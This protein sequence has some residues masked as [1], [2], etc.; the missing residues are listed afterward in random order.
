[1]VMNFNPLVFTNMMLLTPVFAL[2]GLTDVFI[3]FYG[4]FYPI[5]AFG[6]YIM[7]YRKLPGVSK[8]P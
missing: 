6:R 4:V 2:I 8:S 5:A 7:L 3:I 1:M